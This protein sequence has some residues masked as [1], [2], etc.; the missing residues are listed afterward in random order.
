MCVFLFYL[1]LVGTTVEQKVELSMTWD[2]ITLI[3]CHCNVQQ[4]FNLTH[5]TNPNFLSS[6]QT[7]FYKL[8]KKITCVIVWALH[9]SASLHTPLYTVTK[10]PPDNDLFLESVDLSVL[11]WA[12]LLVLTWA[13]FSISEKMKISWNLEAV[14][15]VVW[16]I[17]LLWNFTGISAALLPRYQEIAEWFDY[18][19]HKSCSYKRLW[20]I[21]Q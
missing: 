5:T 6:F 17:V 8:W 4:E 11:T 15:L 2:V 16:I 12:P 7:W 21:F 20:E 19:K 3:W 14:R 10:H 13:P 1:L 9:W 18:S